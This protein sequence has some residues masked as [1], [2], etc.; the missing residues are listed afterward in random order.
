MN[1]DDSL[2]DDEDI[3]RREG[4]SSKRLAVRRRSKTSEMPAIDIWGK[5]PIVS[6][7]D[8][9]HVYGGDT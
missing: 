9:Q 3:L 6:I 5:N 2:P 1:D 7:E 8:C 4:A